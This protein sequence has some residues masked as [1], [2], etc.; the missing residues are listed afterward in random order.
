M[1][2]ELNLPLWLHLSIHFTVAV[3][4]GYLLGL[5]Y[6]KARLGVIAGF[7]AGFLID[8]DHV[9]E[10]FIIYGLQ[11]DLYQF[12]NGY[13]FL[14]SDKIYLVFH[15]YELVILFTL[16]AYLF[17]KKTNVKIFLIIF[18]ISGFLHLVSDS[19]INNYPPKNYTYT[20]RAMNDF[21]A[22]KL[23]N[24]EQYQKNVNLKKE[25]GL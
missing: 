18:T 22:Q 6:K 21:S 1:G 16:L 17:R 25:L 4:G 15:G 14:L 13:Q 3:L 19:V 10:Y 23:L 5:Y 11:F 20:Y 8:L 12:L 9:I 7:L 2:V 24:N